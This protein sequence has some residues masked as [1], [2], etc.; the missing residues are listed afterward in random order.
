[1]KISDANRLRILYFLVFSCTASWLPIFAEYLKDRGLTGIKIGIILSVTPLMMFV[2]QPFYGM[3]ADRFGYKKCLLLSS[4]FASLSFL[5]YLIA[6]GFGWL[7]IITVCMSLFYNSLQPLLDSFSLKLAQDDPSFS[8]GRLRIAGAAGWA[9]TGILVGHYIDAI[10]TTIIFVFSAASLFLTFLFSFSLKLDKK[11]II[12]SGSNPFKNIRQ[13]FGSKILIF[14]LI[15][16]FFISACATTIW[17]YYSIYMKENGASAS[18]VGLG[19]SF[20]GLCELPL[21]YFSAKIIGKFGIR[22]TLLITV[23]ATAIRMLLYSA[24]KNP[25]AAIFIEILH[26]VSWSLF[27]V[28][29]VEYV[30]MLVREDWRVT[31][32]SLLYAAYFGLGAIVG[33]FWTGYLYDA[34]LL[35]SGIFLIN[36]G[37]VGL[38]GLLIWIF[39][40]R[41]MREFAETIN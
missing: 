17:N 40:K 14:L 4:F 16:V 21:F 34:K 39:M 31:G 19:I 5:L 32:Q 2:V 11:N 23:F 41:P 3:L 22:T 29:C 10:N 26:G 38:V 1:M 25:Q 6:G 36:A 15:C 13:V 24:V 33:N 8:Y 18:L 37:L 27:W 9:F 28:V 20:Q 12:V 30:N 7:F 35:I